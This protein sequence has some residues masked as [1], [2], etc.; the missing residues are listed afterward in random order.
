VDEFKRHFYALEG[1]DKEHGWPTRKRFED[2]G[3]GR[4]IKILWDS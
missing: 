1:R 2:L 3:L 4:M